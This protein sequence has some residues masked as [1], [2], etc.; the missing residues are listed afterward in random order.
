MDDKFPM[1]PAGHRKLKADLRQVRDVDRHENVREI[2]AALEHGDLKEN[3]EYHAA[4][5]RQAQ[6]N[7]RKRM[8]EY[9]LAHAVV[10]DPATIK[11]DKVAFGATVTLTDLQSEEKIV[12]SI[13]GE[14][15][16]DVARGLINVN[17]PI[18]RA[19]IGKSEGDDILVKLPRGDREFELLNVEF[20][21]V[22]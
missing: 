9:R 5:E 12:Y 20:K 8:L 21:P 1:T 16:A 10:I 17:S 13:V 22:S 6:L 4:K 18:A 19:M 14:N 2:E 3:A 7:G 15:E 11:S